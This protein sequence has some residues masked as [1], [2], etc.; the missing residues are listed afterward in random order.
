MSTLST[1]RSVV[2]VP[3]HGETI[4]AVHDGARVMV[5]LRPL[6]DRLGLEPNAQRKR[7]QRQP[8]TTAAMMAVVAADGRSRELYCLD[9]ESFPMWLAT[10]ETRR[11]RPEVRAKLEHYQREAAQV[12]RK[13]FFGDRR[14]E[15]LAA[16]SAA[17]EMLVRC[18]VASW[19]APDDDRGERRLR[20][21][22]LSTAIANVCGDVDPRRVVRLRGELAVA[23]ARAHGE[24]L[25]LLADERVEL[26]LEPDLA[27]QVTEG[28]VFLDLML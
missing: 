16:H 10:I 4:G 1:D 12:L 18:A 27:E 22:E 15:L 11:V 3:F 28:T 20:Y 26:G 25:A 24:R 8:W 9:L 19:H 17:V 13:H 5:P 23:Y 6:C 2:H 14:P 21:A 7:L